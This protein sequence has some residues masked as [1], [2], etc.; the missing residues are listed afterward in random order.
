VRAP[1]S[2]D[3]QNRTIML[4]A[5]YRAAVGHTHV[6]YGLLWLE[7]ANSANRPYPQNL[8][9]FNTATRQPI[10]KIFSGSIFFIRSGETSPIAVVGALSAGGYLD[11]EH[12]WLS[13]HRPVNAER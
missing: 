2:A 5:L 1:V 9:N 6:T 13:A 12:C 3:G 10:S 7:G 4:R 8:A 11:V